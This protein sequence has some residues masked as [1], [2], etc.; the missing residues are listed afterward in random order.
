MVM[1]VI[2]SFLISRF[3]II[4]S[5][6]ATIIGKAFIKAIENNDFP[7]AYIF[8]SKNMQ[9]SIPIRSSLSF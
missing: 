2:L 8:L 5:E 3:L 9:N 1:I 7:V 4:D 6:P